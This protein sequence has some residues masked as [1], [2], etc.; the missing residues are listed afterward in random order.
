MSTMIAGAISAFI[1]RVLSSSKWL[2]HDVSLLVL[3]C[4]VVFIGCLFDFL[5]YFF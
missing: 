5:F 1:R 4:V 2:V 3:F